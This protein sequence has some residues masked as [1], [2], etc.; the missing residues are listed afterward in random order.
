MPMR[1]NSVCPLTLAERAFEGML[2]PQFALRFYTTKTH[3]G[4]RAFEA[5]CFSHRRLF[6]FCWEGGVQYND[7]Q[8]QTSTRR[9]TQ[10]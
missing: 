9:Y 7:D 4:N 6:T 8:S 3:T 1:G 2:S 10:T 5:I